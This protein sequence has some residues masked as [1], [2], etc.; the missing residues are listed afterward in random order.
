[1]TEI[2]KEDLVS[3]K[4]HKDLTCF[5]CGDKCKDDSIQKDGKLFCCTGCLYVHELLNDNDL[6]D[7]YTLTQA[8]GLKPKKYEKDEFAY[9]DQ[10]N[11][12]DKL[13]N[14]S[15]SGTAKV[16][17]YIPEVY[18]SACIWLLENL[19]RLDKGILESKV[20]F[21]KKEIAI[22]YKE[23]ITSLRK[24]VELLTSIG[25][26]PK[27]NISDMEGK[28]KT[29]PN[30]TLFI[31]LGIA[32][33]CFG[34][35]ML[36]ALPEYFSG[37]S[38]DP[39][40][41]T[42][43]GYL[44]MLLGILAFYAGSDYYKSAWTSMKLK[45]INI[46]LPISLGI[47]VLFFRSIWEIA[48]ASGPGFIDS[49]TGLIFFLLIGK[50]FRQQTFHS[51]SF[52]RDFKSF[53]PM[54][55]I[56]KSA[57]QEIFISLKDIKVNDLLI[58]RSNEIIPTDAVLFSDSA[59]IDYS[60]VTGESKPIVVKKGDKIYA[61]G[62]QTGSSIE[63]RAI[64]EFEQSYITELWN[65]KAFEK[66]EESYVSHLSNSAAKYF[67]Y[68]ILAIAFTSLIYWLQYDI[69]IAINSFT[70][71]L[72]IA[73]PCALALTMPFTYGTTLRVLS[74]NFMFLK[75]DNIVE[76][77]SKITSI[78]F[79]KTGTLTDI[80]KSKLEYNGQ[81]LDNNNK[82]LIKSAVKH[83]THPLSR[84]I[85]TY[86]DKT[87]IVEIKDFQELA[88]KGIE[89]IY[90]DHNIKV[91]SFKWVKGIFTKV[92]IPNFNDKDESF[93]LESSVYIS[94][95]NSIIG[96]FKVL[97]F[98][99]NDL[100]EMFKNIIHKFKIYILSGDNDNERDKIIEI[101]GKEILM[102]F[103]QL[104]IK[105]LEFVEELQSKNETVL[106]IGDG[107]ND[108]G[109]LKQ[110]NVGVAIADNNSSFTPGS[111]AILLAD[112]LSELPK[113]LDLAKRAMTTVYISFGISILYN[114]IGLSLAVQGILSP[115]IAAIF[116][117]V[118]S[119][120]VIL[121]TVSKVKLDSK[122]LGLK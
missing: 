83:S 111:D 74:K 42:V 109:A 28:K 115:V 13:L 88:G 106:M 4:I 112:R 24:I 32:G 92:E 10:E 102:K 68:I 122:K 113:Y 35:I 29:N 70:A 99:R 17:L 98:Y 69:N 43:I 31:K 52:D 93:K 48:T 15:I 6:N 77:L 16:T 57:A 23:N 40:F 34:N 39:I 107:L 47:F 66:E 60:F 58:V 54:S 84:L 79:D 64:K 59:T 36:L 67:T 73:C 80:N 121:F 11:I 90:N 62:K 87:D 94:I 117:P 30:K 12:K 14:Y 33:F 65:H 55:I 9:L 71:V 105:K 86:F 119:V 97:P 26:K 114:I 38:L 101:A 41:K 44:T 72:I 21:L 27:L 82:I 118:S 53:F 91:G 5:H 22:T 7:F 96:Y 46:D 116:M 89:A 95:D 110:S 103:N 104:P 76:Y 2:N 49:M 108:S 56:K 37:G 85:Y 120:S 19:F 75:N 3:T 61:G 63:I 8:T 1:M 78:V 25:Y 20:N 45:Y 50:V 81:E 18:C 100:P 51:L